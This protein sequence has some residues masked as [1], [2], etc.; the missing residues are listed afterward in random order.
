MTRLAGVEAGVKYAD[1]RQDELLRPHA[2][3]I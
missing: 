2:R 1:R 3:I